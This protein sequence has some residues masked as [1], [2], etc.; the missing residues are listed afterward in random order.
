ML[1]GEDPHT[2]Q[3]LSEENIRYQVCPPLIVALHRSPERFQLVTFLIAGHET[4]R[5]FVF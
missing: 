1:N 4:V 2:H 3:H 5:V